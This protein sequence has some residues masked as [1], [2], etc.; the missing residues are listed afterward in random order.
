LQR[1]PSWRF[2]YYWQVYYWLE[3]LKIQSQSY[4][5]FYSISPKNIT[6]SKIGLRDSEAIASIGSLNGD[7]AT[8]DDVPQGWFKGLIGNLRFWSQYLDATALDRLTQTAGLPTGVPKPAAYWS[9]EENR[10]LQANDAVGSMTATLS[11]ETMWTTTRLTSQLS[12]Y[13][14][15]LA[16]SIRYG[17]DT[18]EYGDREQQLT[19]GALPTNGGFTKPFRGQLD[20]IRIWGDLCTQEEI[21]DN[22]HALLGGNEDGLAGY[23]P[24][25]TA[26]GI[27]IKDASGRGNHAQINVEGND[28]W[29]RPVPLKK[30]YPAPIGSELP[31]VR[32]LLG[33]P[34]TS[35]TI[36]RVSSCGAVE[37]GETQTSPEGHLQAV[38]KRCQVLLDAG[39]RCLTFTGFKVGDLDLHYVGQVQSAP[40]LIGY[41][42]G[43]PPVPSENA[44]RAY[45]TSPAMYTA[46]DNA[47]SVKLVEAEN[48]VQ[49]Y[50]A[51]SNRGFNQNWDLGLGYY[52]SDEIAVGTALGAFFSKHGAKFEFSILPRLTIE[53][54]YDYLSGGGA[55]IETARTRTNMIGTVGDW[56]KPGDVLNPDLGR[57]YKFANVGYAL[58]RSGV[59]NMYSM[60]MRKTGTLMGIT[61]MPDPD[62]K[63]D[64]NIIMFELNPTYTK[65][66]SLDGKIGYK[67]DPDFPAADQERG[68]YFKPKEVNN[69]IK[70]IEAHEASILANYAQFDAGELGRREKG[71]HFQEDDPAENARTLIENNIEMPYDWEKQASKRNIVNTYV[72]TAD[73]GLFVERQETAV[74][75]EESLGGAYAF[76]GMGGISS[77]GKISWAG[78]GGVKWDIK[79]LLGGHIETKVIKTKKEGR[80]FGVD[81]ELNVDGYLRKYTDKPNQYY[82]DADVPGKVRGYRFK[83]FYLVPDKK[84][85]QVFWDKVVSRT[86]LD[87]NDPNAQALRA[88]RGNLNSVWRVMHRVTYV[89]RVPPTKDTVFSTSEKPTRAVIHQISNRAIIWLILDTIYQG[90]TS[91]GQSIAGLGEK[92]QIGTAVAD[93]IDNQWAV[94]V[95]W[96]QSYMGAANAQSSSRSFTELEDVKQAVYDYMLAYFETGA[97]ADDRRPKPEPTWEMT[98][99]RR[100]G[101]WIIGGSFPRAGIKLTI[102]DPSTSTKPIQVT[103]GP[104]LKYGPGGFEV[105][106]PI[107]KLLR[108]RQLYVLT[109]LNQTFQVEIGPEPA[110]IITFTEKGESGPVPARTLTAGSIPVLGKW[111]SFSKLAR[112]PQKPSRER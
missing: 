108:N 33:G 77:E 75:R 65:Q 60:R 13:I 91:T 40:T 68:S 44:T 64:Y 6:N 46:Y 19:F 85:F 110:T 78:V 73:G 74:V 101:R 43:A 51:E 29:K 112:S 34:E 88:A 84:H 83:T 20:E 56:E 98:V 25:S 76:K 82:G 39:G 94:S 107:P 53:N 99:E 1:N 102:T 37:Y 18:V 36:I 105:D 5:L 92:E 111:K 97:A 109:F 81:V 70:Q 57:R 58:V 100:S 45:Y 79:V 7:G 49:I 89:N 27:H 62:I 80:S 42:E 14:N 61:L 22:R 21:Y 32:C 16:A 11:D 72:W 104:N 38:M 63:E 17:G 106:L 59:A 50:S 10:G 47:A 55:E 15:G 96:W 54:N 66:G 52:N 3:Q 41:I 24:I 95:P 67:N 28:F 93:V 87:S 31:Q 12:L 86:W 2:W 23:W 90:M 26:S 48:T 4:N 35:L 69:L 30:D 9:F 103:S 8:A 71:A